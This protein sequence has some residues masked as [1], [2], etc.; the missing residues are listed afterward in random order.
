MLEHNGHDLSIREEGIKNCVYPELIAF[1]EI[2]LEQGKSISETLLKCVDWAERNGHMDKLIQRF[3]VTPEDIRLIKKTINGLS[4]P[5][6]K[7]CISVDKLVKSEL[8]ENIC[9][10]QPLS[11]DQPLITV[12]QT[13]WQKKNA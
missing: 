8:Q 1:I 4:F 6:K 9:Y 12:M 3:Y 5:D 13:P 7:V 11:E 10:Y 2:W